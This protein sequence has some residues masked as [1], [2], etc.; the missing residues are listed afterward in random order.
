VP[1][2][3]LIAF[4]AICGTCGFTSRLAAGPKND[5]GS[6]AII[7][8]SVDTKGFLDVLHKAGV[9]VIGRYYSRCPQPDIV[10][11]KRIIDNQGEIESILSHKAGFGIL[12]IYQYY[13]G[14]DKKFEGL[15]WDKKKRKFLVLPGDDCSTPA[16]QPNSAEKEAELDVGAAIKQARDIG[17]PKGSA[18]YFGIDYNYSDDD[19]EKVLRYFR[20]VSKELRNH[21]YLVG[22]YGNGAAISLL[23]TEK[24]KD[25]K[26]KGAP[27]VDLAWLAGNRG[28]GSAELYN[29]SEWDLLQTKINIRLPA[30]SL[31]SIEID[32]NIQNKDRAQKYIGFWS[33]NGRYS[34]PAERTGASLGGEVQ[35]QL[36]ILRRLP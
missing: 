32:K 18:I 19:K 15:Y 11:E 3:L 33:R 31:G 24:C 25:G 7:D 4:I 6:I 34:V 13:S 16:S 22:V 17:Q 1:V 35:G 23:K 2:R 36:P 27:L 10:P 12:S 5:P 20:V 21:G 9:K 26:F 30:G 29:S 8:A 28:Q 14:S